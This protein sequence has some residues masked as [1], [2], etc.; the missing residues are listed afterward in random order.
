MG[1]MSDENKI[2]LIFR[3]LIMEE[4]IKDVCLDLGFN[5]S[6]GRNLILKFKK[7]GEYDGKD[8]II[9]GLEGLP[10][11]F[12]STKNSNGTLP[13]SNLGIIFLDEENVRLVNTKECSPEEEQEILRLHMEFISRLNEEE[14]AKEDKC[15]LIGS[16]PPLS[17][18]LSLIHISEPTR[19][20]YISYAV[21]CLKKKKKKPIK[22]LE[23]STLITKP[24][25]NQ[26]AIFR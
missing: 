16:F 22:S 25:S 23:S 6:T 10:K 11:P 5:F 24:R 14:K 21:F 15:Q 4:N 12:S 9:Q 17:I 2:D 8:R 1:H 3:V 20:L 13:L 19:P 7:T 18:S 26:S